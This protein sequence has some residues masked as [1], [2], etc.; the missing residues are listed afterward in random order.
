VYGS[1]YEGHIPAKCHYSLSEV[2][3][4][5]LQFAAKYLTLN[6]RLVFWLPVYRQR[7]VVSLYHS[8]QKTILVLLPLLKVDGVGVAT[9]G[10]ALQ[11][12]PG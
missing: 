8:R 10:L 1:S 12:G 2:M 4:D 5:L 6:G 9:C 3:T 7:S 11:T